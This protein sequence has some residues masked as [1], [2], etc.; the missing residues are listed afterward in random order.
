MKTIPVWETWLAPD[1]DKFFAKFEPEL[2]SQR[3]ILQAIDG[4]YLQTDVQ[5]LPFNLE[6]NLDFQYAMSLVGPLPVLDIQVG[7]SS[8]W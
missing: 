4:G 1:L 5:L 3:P 2:V 6:A 7:Q 8:F